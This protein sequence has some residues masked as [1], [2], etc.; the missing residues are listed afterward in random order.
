MKKHLIDRLDAG[1]ILIA[2]GS[3][4][5][6]LMAAGL[7]AGTPPELWNVENTEQILSLHKAFLDA[8]SQIILTNTF[9]GT[10]IKLE[11]AGLGERTIELNRH[12]A[13]LA[14]EAAGDQAY[15]AGD[16]G[17][18]GELMAPLGKL[19]FERAL[20]TFTEQ[21]RVL[22]DEGV[23]LLWVE[24]MTDLNEARAAVMGAKKAGDLPIFCSLSFGPKGRTIMG[25]RAGQAAKELW[26]LGLTAVGANCGE[27]I[28]PVLEALKQMQEVLPGA[29][30]IAKPNAG[31]PRL[32]DGKTVYSMTPQDFS[33]HTPEFVALGAKIIGGCCGSTHEHVA[34]VAAAVKNLE[35]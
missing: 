11:K 35:I 4:G 34:A 9:G 16:L 21:A 30:L 6:T 2:D 32:V 27:G 15:V 13:K 12:A 8:G 10:R 26:D 18:T 23:D 31:L 33:A 25:V 17:P 7:P 14:R 24:T 28:P 3:T 20:E 19:T 1:E 22:A 29:P 5:A